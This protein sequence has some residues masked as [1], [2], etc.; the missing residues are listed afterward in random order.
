MESKSYEEELRALKERYSE[1]R[2]AP[3]SGLTRAETEAELRRIDERIQMLEATID[4]VRSRERSAPIQAK[5]EPLATDGTPSEGPPNEGSVSANSEL[6]GT[7]PIM[8][9]FSSS[10]AEPTEQTQSS[11]K[12]EQRT[13]QVREESS[14]F[15]EMKRDVGAIVVMSLIGLAFA[16][17]FT[18]GLVSLLQHSKLEAGAE[19][20]I[21][22]GKLYLST[23][24][25]SLT[26]TGA[27]AIWKIPSLYGMNVHWGWPIVVL[28]IGAALTGLPVQSEGGGPIGLGLAALN[29]FATAYGTSFWG[30]FAVGVAGGLILERVVDYLRT[31]QP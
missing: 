10:R 21:E 28:A 14:G 13:D 30:G 5:F 15:Q 8:I 26:L 12:H 17:G 19:D 25:L 16:Q 29:T 22:F 20:Y 2:H 23:L 3:N 31:K 27:W 1:L 4:N 7:P 24:L 9:P 6:D 18:D 11:S